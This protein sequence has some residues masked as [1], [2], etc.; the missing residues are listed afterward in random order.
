[1]RLVHIQAI[2]CILLIAG[3]SGKNIFV[4]Q[5]EYPP[6]ANPTHYQS[7]GSVVLHHQGK[8]SKVRFRWERSQD[9]FKASVYGPLGIK[10]KTLEGQL[11]NIGYGEKSR[12]AH[13]TNSSSVTNPTAEQLQAGAEQAQDE[14]IDDLLA[15]SYFFRSNRYPLPDLLNQIIMAEMMTGEIIQTQIGELSVK[16][17]EYWQHAGVLSGRLPRKIELYGI[18]DQSAI[19]IAFKFSRHRIHS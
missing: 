6:Q 8:K 7:S 13:A 3:C 5:V 14:L 19:L 17:I 2:T 18:I 4:A 12:P 16:K 15:S 9:E 1:M 10:L 11:L